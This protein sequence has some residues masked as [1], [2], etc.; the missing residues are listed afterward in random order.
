M[1]ADQVEA[2]GLVDGVFDLVRRQLGREV[3]EDRDRV[4]DRDALDEAGDAEVG[5]SVQA[6]ARATP[7]GRGGTD[8]SIGPVDLVGRDPPELGGAPMAEPRVGPQANVAA[9]SAPRRPTSGR[10]TA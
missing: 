1:G 8:T 2:V 10:P 3:D 5:P 7:G 6:D 4:G 9:F